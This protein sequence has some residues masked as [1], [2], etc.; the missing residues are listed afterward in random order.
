MIKQVVGW[1]GACA[2]L[3]VGTLSLVRPEVMRN[4]IL[5]QYRQALAARNLSELSFLLKVVPGTRIFRIYGVFSLA[6]AGLIIYALLK[7]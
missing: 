7:N 2:L 5:E 4:F 6:T 1:A 3:F